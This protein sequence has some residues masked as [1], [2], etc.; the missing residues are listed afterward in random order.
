MTK[1]KIDL[2]EDVSNVQIEGRGSDI[3]KLLVRLIHASPQVKGLLKDAIEHQESFSE[4][5][6]TKENKS[7][8]QN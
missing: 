7:E 2:S 6:K 4:F 1:V 8:K 5:M 3:L